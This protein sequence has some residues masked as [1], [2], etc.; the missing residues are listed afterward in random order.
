MNLQLNAGK[1]PALIQ[2]VMDTNRLRISLESAQALSAFLMLQKLLINH[3]SEHHTNR[4]AD[5]DAH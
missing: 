5:A 4:P 1:D 2:Q 3:D